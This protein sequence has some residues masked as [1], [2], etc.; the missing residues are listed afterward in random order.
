MTP[1]VYPHSFAVYKVS[2]TCLC[3]CVDD[4]SISL[5]SPKSS[6]DSAKR[7]ILNSQQTPLSRE[8]VGSAYEAKIEG[9]Q[10]NGSY[11][12]TIGAGC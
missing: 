2:L 6:L 1:S 3:T 7:E 10:V 5:A 11:N 4:Q 9:D 12:Y 8:L